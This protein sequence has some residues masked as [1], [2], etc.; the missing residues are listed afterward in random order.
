MDLRPF[1]ARHEIESYLPQAISGCSRGARLLALPRWVEGRAWIA[2][3]GALRSVGFDPGKTMSGWTW[4]EFE[5]LCE[6]LKAKRFVPAM[7]DPSS[8]DL[9]TDLGYEPPGEPQPPG[10]SPPPPTD[11]GPPRVLSSAPAELAR[12][13]VR[14]GLARAQIV[15]GAEWR[16]LDALAGG[17]VGFAAGLSPI[18]ASE[19][20]ARHSR[21]SFSPVL[22]PV[23]TSGLLRGHPVRTGGIIVFRQQ[24]YKGG[25][26]T[27][28]V[29]NLAK[30]LSTAPWDGA[31]PVLLTPAYRPNLGDWTE[32]H[33]WNAVVALAS[34]QRGSPQP[35]YDSA[36]LRLKQLAREKARIE[37]KRGFSRLQ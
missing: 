36:E 6:Q 19:I 18:L 30:A 7:V 37:L 8:P 31:L 2:N 26:H 21:D 14:R 29:V 24:Q 20:V 3:A 35:L 34:V 11:T 23:P 22:M 25:Q 28:I 9:M 12:S 5:N 15:G 32:A 17:N 10:R 4:R 16:T 1:L 13:L 33:G 27:R